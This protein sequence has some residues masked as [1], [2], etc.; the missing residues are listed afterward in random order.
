MGYVGYRD[1]FLPKDMGGWALGGGI[2]A[3]GSFMQAEAGVSYGID[4]DTLKLG[5]WSWSIGA[6]IQANPEPTYGAALA[7]GWSWGDNWE[8]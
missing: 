5:A 3:G 6:G 7:L 4:M 2:Q 8:N 1:A